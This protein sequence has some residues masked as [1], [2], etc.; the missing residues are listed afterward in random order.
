ML[1]LY[2]P[3]LFDFLYKIKKSVFL[4]FDFRKR[5]VSSSVYNFY[6]NKKKCLLDRMLKIVAI[7]PLKY[8]KSSKHLKA[9]LLKIFSKM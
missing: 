7:L 2:L 6:T 4:L 3:C 8:E 9:A 1:F 5:K